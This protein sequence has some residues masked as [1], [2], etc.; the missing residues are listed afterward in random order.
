M[1]A[2]LQNN[3]SL[4]CSLLPVSLSRR[5]SAGTEKC[6]QSNRG[7]PRAPHPAS[8]TR[9]A[10]RAQW[11]AVESHAP[12]EVQRCIPFPFFGLRFPTAPPPLLPA[13]LPPKRPAPRLLGSPARQGRGRG[14][15]RAGVEQGQARDRGSARRRGMRFGWI[16]LD[17]HPVA[18]SPATKGATGSG[19][20]QQE[21]RATTATGRPS[22]PR[23]HKR[24]EHSEGT[25]QRYL[26]HEAT[27]GGRRAP[28]SCLRHKPEERQQFSGFGF[29][30]E[31]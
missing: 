17:D 13:C 15:G 1:N 23:R 14:R 9:Q 6:T 25:K 16:G 19:L 8:R 18:S 30:D 7:A 10:P 20:P 28:L 27:Y 4:S 12:H 11:G 31:R 21:P 29:H 24:T 22:T 3:A 26:R 2:R 5:L